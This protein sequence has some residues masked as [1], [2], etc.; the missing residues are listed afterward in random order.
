MIQLLHLA[1]KLVVHRIYQ[2]RSN[3][4]QNCKKYQYLIRDVNPE[5]HT[6]DKILHLVNQGQHQI[7]MKWVGLLICLQKGQMLMK[8]SH[9]IMNKSMKIYIMIMVGKNK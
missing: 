8:I 1:I 7:I 5:I 3:I 6:Q 2:F 4:H 9:M